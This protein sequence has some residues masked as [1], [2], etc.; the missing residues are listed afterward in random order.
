MHRDVRATGRMAGL[1]LAENLV[2][3][4]DGELPMTSPCGGAGR[5]RGQAKF[6]LVHFP[7]GM[8]DMVK[9]WM[10]RPDLIEAVLIQHR[11]ADRELRLML[12]GAGTGSFDLLCAFRYETD[13]GKVRTSQP[14]YQLLHVGQETYDEFIEG[15]GEGVT[16]HKRASELDPGFGALGSYQGRRG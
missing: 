2:N 8:T 12:A 11:E 13:G 10:R 14:G 15:V 9:R 4:A 6:G 5:M 16:Q 1:L 3:L 7:E